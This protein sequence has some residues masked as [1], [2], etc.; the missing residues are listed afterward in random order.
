V[1]TVT[2]THQN[3]INYGAVLQAYALQQQLHK[4]CINDEIL[5]LKRT[6][7]IFNKVMFNKHLPGNIYSSMSNLLYLLQTKKRVKRFREFVENNI[8]TTRHYGTVE[9]VIKNPPVA[10]AYI[11]GSDQ[12]FNT[13]S[14]I[15]PASFLRFGSKETKR[16]SY[17]ASMGISAVKDEYLDEFISAI[18]AYTFLSVREKSAANYISKLC[19]VPCS[20]NIDPVL[21]LTQEEWLPLASS[22]RLSPSMKQRKYILVYNLL[23]NP[24]LNDAVKRIKEETGFEVVVINPHAICSVK[25]DLIVRDAGPLEF[26]K[27]FKNAEYI[28][29]TSFH[30]TCFSILFQKQFFSFI[31]KAG[32]TRI[33]NLLNM[34]NIN[35]RIITDTSEVISNGIPYSNVNEIIEMERKKANEY[36]IRALGT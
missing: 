36:L 11:T 3:A 10:D 23:E 18:K 17:A 26:L 13:Y 7:K 35:D 31:R 22:S 34:L 28:L 33:P 4:L 14:G 27:L 24:L 19:S 9:G 29:T 6:D 25:G 15:K 2:V 32:E 1:K 5:D 30:G 20:T 8:N 16:I 12:T 21:L